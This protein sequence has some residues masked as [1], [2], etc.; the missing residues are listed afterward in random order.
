M[1]AEDAVLVLL[2]SQE[3]NNREMFAVYV[4]E[5][6]FAKLSERERLNYF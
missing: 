2:G 5:K 1:R 6:D 4:G 3:V